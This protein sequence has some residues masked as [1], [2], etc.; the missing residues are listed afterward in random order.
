MDEAEHGDQAGDEAGRLP[1]RHVSINQVIAY[2]VTHYRR[3]AGLTQEQ[4]GKRLGGWSTAS[5]S[6]AERSWDGKRPRKFDGDEIV[7]IAVALGVPVIALFLPPADAGTAV[8]YVLDTEPGQPD[9]TSLLPGLADVS[10]EGTPALAALRHRI[11]ALGAGSY[12]DPAVGEAMAILDRA[13]AEA[14]D[15][16][17]QSRTRSEQVTG[18]ARSRAEALEHDAQERHRAAMSSLLQ[19]REELEQRVDDLRAFERLYRAGLLT[20]VESLARDLRAGAVVE[21]G[22][23]E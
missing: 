10:A 23:Q 7:S 9:I 22:D 13:R 19:S 17:G 12:M 14:D 20:Y 8:S 2:N 3:A 18:Q 1:E 5:V 11:M 21:G 16:L 15:L 4:L 6:A